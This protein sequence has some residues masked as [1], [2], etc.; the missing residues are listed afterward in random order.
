MILGGWHDLRVGLN[1]GDKSW[2]GGFSSERGDLG[3]SVRVR[4]RSASEV[5]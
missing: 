3:H 2:V 4:D 5:Y 1:P